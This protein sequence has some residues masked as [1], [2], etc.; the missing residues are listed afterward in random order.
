MTGP[1]RRP[2]SQGRQG[3]TLSLLRRVG[4]GIFVVVAGGEACAD[5]AAREGLDGSRSALRWG[6]SKGGP[7]AGHGRVA[8]FVA[9]V[10]IAGLVAGCAG[11]STPS[12]AST[13]GPPPASPPPPAATAVP[14]ASPAAVARTAAPT[15][16]LTGFSVR[17]FGVGYATNAF[18]AVDADG[19]VYLPGGTKGAALVKMAPDG[20]VLARWAGFDVV[21]G[22]P[23]TIVGIAVDPT[24]GDVWATDTT[25]DAVV[26]LGSDLT[27]KGRWGAT[28][29]ATGQL[30][31]PGGIAVDPAG[32]IVVAD[33]G[34]DRIQ[35]FTSDGTFVSA[36]AAPGGKT[37]PYD[38][39]V[40]T[41]GDVVAS[42]VQP[43]A[44]FMGGS[45]VLRLS[46]TGSPTLT[47]ADSAGSP[48]NFPD[49]AVDT[50]G[51]I[52]VADPFLGL[53]KY[54]PD[55]APLGSWQIPGGGQAA[56]AAR[57]APSGDIY[58][59]ACAGVNG[60]CTLAQNTADMQQVATWHA[61]TPVDHPGTTVV[62]NGNT[63]YLQCVGS[64]SP[65][66]VWSAGSDISGWVTTAQ[67]L[68]GKLAETSRVC[69]YDRPGQ[70]WSGPG[71]YDE[72]SHWS[73][74]VADMHAALAKA[75]EKGPFVI[76]GH[77]YGGLL[78]RLFALTYPKDVAGIVSID[79][80]HEDEWAGPA[81]DQ[82]APFGITTCLDASC[83]L[84][85]DIQA[86]TKL[87]G[88]KVAGSL[89]ALPLIVL[90]HAPDLPF[91]S[92]DYDT[93]WEK[94]GTD[95]ATASSNARH[96]IASWSTHTI[97]NTQPGLVVEAVKQVV[98]AA[99]ASDHTL[100]A[101]GTAFTQVGG[102][103]VP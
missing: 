69:V 43:L 44:L 90:S 71:G 48:L 13:S 57:V 64:G 4:R 19:D 36:W 5:A 51:N 99:R 23:D 42:T 87:E 2:G 61:S 93:L 100:P 50:A 6:A 47:I 86:M 20:T 91:W 8:G 81:T 76:V 58:T 74:V 92:A 78:A 101:C 96:V 94:L 18:F 10:A 37:A 62:V 38:V 77:S 40:A 41:N 39:A 98:D 60:D 75:G 95:T 56:V 72:V 53:L 89:G 21:P 3:R 88:G 31:S 27:Q 46:S 12:P 29:P 11:S 103:C 15:V 55:G 79:P 33:M 7:V 35:T 59:L 80:S 9:C 73:Q 66:I 82:F 24:T 63:A 16:E 14:S 32:D 1:G 67:Y 52:W 54:G 25:A 70:G 34:N 26:H 22:Q 68:M 84:Y 97:P 85:G 83:P 45:K 65:T 49:A 17:P 30:S 28:G 102:E